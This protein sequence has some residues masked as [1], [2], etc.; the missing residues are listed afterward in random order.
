MSKF[1]GSYED[2]RKQ[3]GREYVKMLKQGETPTIANAMIRAGYTPL[4]A[5]TKT[6]QIAQSKEFT[7]EVSKYLNK[8][9]KLEDLT[10]QRALE[11]VG[12]A[13]YR[14]AIHGIDTLSKAKRLV[15]SS[16]VDNVMEETDADVI[17]ER[18]QRITI[19][20]RTMDA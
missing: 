13:S 8:L 5:N 17:L 19:K 6:K 2:R 3:V 15:M 1:K 4:T 18:I 12:E 7:Q 16:N 14:D 9:D 20:R 11:T 10:I